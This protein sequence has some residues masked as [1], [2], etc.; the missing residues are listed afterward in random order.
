VPGNGLLPGFL[1]PVQDSL[2]TFR[3][4]M[5]AMAH[6]GR[7]Y[8]LPVLP[9]APAPLYPS[10][11]AVCL[12]LL[13]MDTPL[14]IEPSASP[15][16]VINYLKFH[17]GCAVTRDAAEAAFAIAGPGRSLPELAAFGMGDPLYPH[18]STTV[19]IQVESLSDLSL[20]GV[21]IT[22]PG[23]AEEIRVHAEGL[24]DAF[25]PALHAN[26]EQF[27]QGVDVLLISPT[28]LCGL[29]RTVKV[30]PDGV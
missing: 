25:W 14:W 15:P 10:T 18:Q 27:P 29:P 23:I 3:V 11:A 4:I 24:S 22:G 6:P 7:K 9:Q 17:C 5:N 21:A 13:D 8:E 16:E 26:N 2:K 28:S 20:R 1:D 19:L 30:F 12:T